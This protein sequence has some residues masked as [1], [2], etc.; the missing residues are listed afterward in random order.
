MVGQVVEVLGGVVEGC[1]QSRDGAVDLVDLILRVRDG[2]G[3]SVSDVECVIIS[4][5]SVGQGL[6][7]IIEESLE[8]GDVISCLVKSILS[9]I[10]D[11]WSIVQ[12]NLSIID[13]TLKCRDTACSIIKSILSILN[14]LLSISNGPKN[15]INLFLEIGTIVGGIVE[16]VGDIVDGV[17]EVGIIIVVEV[18]LRLDVAD[19]VVN[20]VEVTSVG[21]L[22]GDGLSELVGGGLLVAESVVEVAVGSG[23][24][25][26]VDPGDV[27]VDP[28][29]CV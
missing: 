20:G 4:L 22:V 3:G 25:V 24:R 5:L 2:L 9:L 19:V 1:S 15:I 26:I 8:V 10:D 23:D 7:S 11:S 28:L 18:N 13:D 16:L 21:C 6:L 12:S 29:H 14:C 27:G 17:G